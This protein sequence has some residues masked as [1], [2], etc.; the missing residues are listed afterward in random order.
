MVALVR[1]EV[2]EEYN[3][4]REDDFHVARFDRVLAELYDHHGG[5]V[6]A[7]ELDAILRL[8][9]VGEHLERGQVIVVGYFVRRIGD[10]DRI[11]VMEDEVAY[12]LPEAVEDEGGVRFL[13]EE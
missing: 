3:A 9:D 5:F 8:V 4:G 7:N 6:V 13:Q 1:E 2:I 11:D 10:V 12:G